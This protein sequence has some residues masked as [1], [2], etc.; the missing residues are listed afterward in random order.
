MAKRAIIIPALFLFFFGVYFSFDFQVQAVDI[1]YTSIAIFLFAVL[2][3]FFI[4]RQR[5]R[6]AGIVE[7]VT[8][9]DGHMSALYREF[10]FFGDNAQKTFET[11]A[12][13]HYEKIINNDSWES[14]FANKT[15]TIS[16]TYLLVQ[17]LAGERELTALRSATVTRILTSLEAMQQIRKN[18]IALYKEHVPTFQWV[19]LFFLAFTLVAAVSSL[20]SAG[21][22]FQSLLKAAF[23]SSV[24]SV[25]IMLW[26]LN[27]LTFFEEMVG[28]SSAQDVLDIFNGVK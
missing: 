26:Q 9:F 10:A 12:R 8:E 2:S 19:L 1:V 13:A 28:Q 18:L 7:K 14:Y 11:T 5:T 22:L 24:I 15:N 6:Y 23:T 25:L 27:T 4:A 17:T 20:S 16:D 3:G 21:L